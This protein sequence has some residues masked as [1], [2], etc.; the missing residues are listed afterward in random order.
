MSHAR[1]A[2]HP[3][4]A[5]AVL[6]AERLTALRRTALLDAA[7]DGSFDRFTRVVAHLLGAPVALVS[8]V[9]ADGQF[10]GGRSPPR[11][12]PPSAWCWR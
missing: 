7:A 10:F 8:L 5:A 9:D 12:C 11:A 4:A 3:A 6:A 2:P 1:S